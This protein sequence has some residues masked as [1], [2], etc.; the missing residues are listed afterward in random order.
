MTTLQI[1]DDNT[2]RS[3]LLPS[4]DL[5][6]PLLEQPAPLPVGSGATSPGSHVAERMH[7]PMPPPIPPPDPQGQMPDIPAPHLATTSS[8]AGSGVDLRS[9][10]VGEGEEEWHDEVCAAADGCMGCSAIP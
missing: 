8:G 7:H 5:D 6:D 1:A 4:F 2:G 9:L 3:A 10:P